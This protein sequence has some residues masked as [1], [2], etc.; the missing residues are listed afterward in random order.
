MT[1]QEI[2]ALLLDGLAMV[3]VFASFAGF[4]ALLAIAA[5]AAT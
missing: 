3:V 4:L 2:R 1:L 5:P